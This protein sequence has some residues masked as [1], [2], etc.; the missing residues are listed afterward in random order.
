MQPGMQEWL[1]CPNDGVFRTKGVTSSPGSHL[2]ASSRVQLFLSHSMI[3]IVLDISIITRY[4]DGDIA[5]MKEI[6]HAG[7]R[8]S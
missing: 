4:N 1:I 7:I 8:L 2:C 3:F 6:D 5:S